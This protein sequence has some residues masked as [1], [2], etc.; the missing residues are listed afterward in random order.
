M[1]AIKSVS[2]QVWKQATTKVFNTAKTHAVEATNGGLLTDG[3]FLH[4]L[5]SCVRSLG[6]DQKYVPDIL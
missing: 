4:F 2:L 5:T 6:S 1:G 3:G